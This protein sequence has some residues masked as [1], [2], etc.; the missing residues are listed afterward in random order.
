MACNEVGSS[1]PTVKKNETSK[2]V[3]TPV[4]TKK[5]E[6]T[7]V[8]PDAI[9][10]SKLNTKLTPMPDCDAGECT[11]VDFTVGFKVGEKTYSRKIEDGSFTRTKG[12]SK[13]DERVVAVQTLYK[14]LTSL[15]PKNTKVYVVQEEVVKIVQAEQW[16]G[17]EFTPEVVLWEKQS[18]YGKG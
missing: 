6:P 13:S 4:E 7:I 12:A 3:A 15:V 2:M 1:Q 5:P 10:L 17:K 18:Y 16:Q 14:S 8:V 11:D 9:G